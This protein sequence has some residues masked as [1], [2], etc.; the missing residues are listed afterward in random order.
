[1][2]YLIPLLD[3]TESF[4]SPDQLLSGA[5]SGIGILPPLTHLLE[6]GLGSG[7]DLVAEGLWS[8]D[9]RNGGHRP[10]ACTPWG[11]KAEPDL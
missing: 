11:S 10:N 6:A 4:V 2:N 9:H 8:V 1:M 3:S 5:F 7:I